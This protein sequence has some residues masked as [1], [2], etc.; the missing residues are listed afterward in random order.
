MSN[1]FNC[2][3]VIIAYAWRRKKQTLPRWI[4]SAT[5]N[6]DQLVWI[7]RHHYKERLKITK[8]AKFESDTS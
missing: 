2:V 5:S 4:F 3:N 6:M 1:N 7:R 8:L